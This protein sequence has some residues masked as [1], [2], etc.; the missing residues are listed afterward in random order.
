[1]H[2]PLGLAEDADIPGFADP[3]LRRRARHVVSENDRVRG[4]VMALQAGDAAVA[5]QL[6]IESHESLAGDFDASTPVVDALVDA[7]VTRPGV[8]GARVTGGGFGGCVVALA[9]PG[10]LDPGEW[11]G[12]A[13]RVS[14][15]DGAAVRPVARPIG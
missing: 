11:P 5:G 9:R 8:F 1:M 4:M 7:L 10:S 14:A 3:V 15:A 13:W 12:R 2:C 6:M